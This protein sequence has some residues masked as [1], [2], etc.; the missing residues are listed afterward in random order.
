[1]CGEQVRVE[2]KDRGQGA[3][4]DVEGGAVSLGPAIVYDEAC[5]ET[6]THTHTHTHTD[7]THIHTHADAHA[8]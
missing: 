2:C 1:M 3:D 4:C 8:L 5:G 6:H 7:G